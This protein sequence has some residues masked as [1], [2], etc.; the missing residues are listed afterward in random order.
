MQTKQH[1][2]LTLAA[3]AMLLSAAFVW[4]ADA[5]SARP[6]AQPT[7]VAVIDIVDIID[8]LNE[9]E[10]LKKELNARMEA[11]QATLDEVLK[12]LEIL[13]ED[14]KMLK[15]GT[16]EHREKLRE[17]LEKQAVAKA[18]REA[19]SQI[20][21]IDTGSVMAGLYKKVEAA[22]KNIAE[23]EGYDIVLFDDSKFEI[24]DGAPDPEVYRAIITK[25][26]I[27]RHDSIDITQQVITLMN[28]EYSAP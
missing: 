27:Y 8:G 11:R 16:P 18:R 3:I 5:T 10:V 17:G 6:P 1:T 12:E 9:R 13:N 21:S 14:I 24:P 25:S 4:R 20:V 2:T 22:I 23:R 19:L 28:N 15:R 26:V 7:A